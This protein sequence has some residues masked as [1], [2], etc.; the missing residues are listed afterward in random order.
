MFPVHTVMIR[1]MLTMFSLFP[2]ENTGVVRSLMKT[3]VIVR[4]EGEKERQAVYSLT[5]THT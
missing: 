2:Q 5:G 3:W 4:S 1:Y